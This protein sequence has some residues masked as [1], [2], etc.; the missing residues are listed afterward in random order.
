MLNTIHKKLTQRR[1][2]S[3]RSDPN[4]ETKPNVNI[5]VIRQIVSALCFTAV[6]SGYLQSKTKMNCKD[7]FMIKW[8]V[9]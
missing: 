7:I 6:T 8:G 2:N 3:C 9:D 1:D 4:P 5:D